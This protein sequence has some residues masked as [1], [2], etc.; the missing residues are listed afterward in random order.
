MAPRPLMGTGQKA[1]HW[2][3]EFGESIIAS[4]VENDRND[5][6]NIQSLKFVTHPTLKPMR[7]Y[8]VPVAFVFAIVLC[9]VA[10]AA[11]SLP[12]PNAKLL[13]ILIVP[14]LMLGVP[15]GIWLPHASVWPMGKL[16]RVP[17]NTLLLP[18]PLVSLIGTQ[19]IGTSLCALALCV[20]T[21]ARYGLLF[22][23]QALV[24]IAFVASAQRRFNRH[25]SSE[26]VMLWKRHE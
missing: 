1:S 26:F 8:S 9:A 7:P 6:G 23:L 18:R 19:A 16:F 15:F 24:A 10:M 21:D 14:A 17:S 22:I 2:T 11:P 4:A 13:A 12:L 25:P 3:F 20:A 5:G